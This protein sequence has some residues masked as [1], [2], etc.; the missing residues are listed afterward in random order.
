MRTRG[1]TISPRRGAHSD[2]VD[3]AVSSILGQIGCAKDA[4][5]GRLDEDIHVV[6][7]VGGRP[8]AT[9][10]AMIPAKATTQATTHA[11]T[12]VTHASD[13]VREADGGGCDGEGEGG[14][15]DG[16]NGEGEVPH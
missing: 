8:E 5:G 9:R 1:R 14:E 12:Q 16:S 3:G 6:S 11:T 7:D 13:R 4:A 15:R 2:T 10:C